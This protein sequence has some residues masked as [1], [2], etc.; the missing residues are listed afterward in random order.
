MSR[1]EVASRLAAFGLAL[2]A[3]PAPVGRYRAGIVRNGIGVLSGQFP[4]RGGEMVYRG[5]LGRD[6]STVE[7]QEAARVAALNA[8]AQIDSLLGGFERLAGL[9]R[10]DGFIAS[11][12]DWVEHAVVLDA[13][14]SLFADV[15]EE[16]GAHARSAMGVASL[17]LAAP[18]ELVVTFATLA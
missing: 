18:V 7:G 6:L 17:P 13:A 16:R 4:L 2:P 14:S 3:A 8:L 9:L 10:V 15:L 11:A 5:V 12:P 1:P